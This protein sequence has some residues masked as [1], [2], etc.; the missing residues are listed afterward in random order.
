WAVIHGEKETGVTTFRLQHAIDTGG[1][2]L[3]TSFPIGENETTGEVHDRMKLIGAQLLV[4]TVKGLAA[5]TLSE[6]PQSTLEERITGTLHNAPKIFTETCII[7][8]NQPVATVHNLV[9]GLSPFPGALTKL[10]GKTLKLY[11]SEK[12]ITQH[13]FP[14]GLVFSD[15]KTYLKFSC[16]DGYLQIL[17]LQLEGKKR[18]LVADFLRGYHWQKPPSA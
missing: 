14:A 15:Q 9:R 17:D 12:E 10:E 2:L 18:M 3:Q 6:T 8:W 7:D 5:G 4:T 13:G 11:R 1:V 16:T